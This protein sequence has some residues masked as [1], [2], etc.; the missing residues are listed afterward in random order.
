MKESLHRSSSTN[1]LVPIADEDPHSHAHPLYGTIPSCRS[2]TSMNTCSSSRTGSSFNFLHQT[3]SDYQQNRYTQDQDRLRIYQAAEEAGLSSYGVTA[4][5]VWYI[6][7]EAGG[8]NPPTRNR[9]LH[10]GVLWVSPQ[11]SQH[12]Q[13]E[14][15][16]RLVNP[17]HPRY[18]VPS[19]QVAGA[20]LAGYFYSLGKSKDATGGLIWRNLSDIISDP[21]QPP[22][23][24]MLIWKEAGFGKVTGI[25]FDVVNGHQGV[26]LYFARSRADEA[27][28]NEP[29]NVEFISMATQHIG[30]TSALCHVRQQSIRTKSRKIHRIWKRVKTKI[31]CY[32][33]FVSLLHQKRSLQHHHSLQTLVRGLSFTSWDR[34]SSES[35][36]MRFTVHQ[37][38]EEPFIFLNS[39]AQSLRMWRLWDEAKFRILGVIDKSKG[40]SIRPPPAVPWL[41]ATWTFVGVYVTLLVLVSID[42]LLLKKFG[43]PS[44]IL[45]PFGA[46]LTLQYSLTAAPV[47][48]PRNILYGLCVCLSI[49]LLSQGLLMH[50]FGFPKEMVVPLAGAFG[51]S[52]MTKLGVTHPP[53]AAAMVALL[54]HYDP[55]SSSSLKTL[56]SALLLVMAN[57][58]T[59]MTSILINNL[60]E[61]RQYPVYW[62]LG[63]CGTSS[64]VALHQEPKGLAQPFVLH[65]QTIPIMASTDGSNS[66]T[67]PLVHN[68]I[69]NSQYQ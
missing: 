3:I 68:H 22:Y 2:S 15:L 19:P 60:S 16:D 67:L 65:A 62:A 20:G 52:I 64:K 46:S 63:G 44:L 31:F 55:V 1:R 17:N 34:T 18:V 33:T 42:P 12:N 39:T 29:T 45:A 32:N 51:I 23:E 9:I 36:L 43:L 27:L 25:A 56:T 26:V 47:S 53:A 59:I 21:F 10:T 50:Q 38:V 69:A 37:R 54:D 58:L 41:N 48:Q 4:V 49:T 11:F 6:G 57:L 8:T 7:T 13:S 35:S 40:S 66:W 14:A 28:L 61:Q 30:I 24:R 5:D